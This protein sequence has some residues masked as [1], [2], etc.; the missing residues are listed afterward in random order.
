MTA[1]RVGEIC[2]LHLLRII[3]THRATAILFSIY[4]CHC[5]TLSLSGIL[6]PSHLI[7]NLS[8]LK[9]PLI[10]SE[11]KG[12]RTRNSTAPEETLVS[13]FHSTILCISKPLITILFLIYKMQKRITYPTGLT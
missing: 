6:N 8:R 4:S 13:A 9:G 5:P 1:A 7:T 10:T 11:A 12:K 3:F 2:D